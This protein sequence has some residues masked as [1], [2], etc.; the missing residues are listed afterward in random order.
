MKSQEIE[1]FQVEE[2]QFQNACANAIINCVHDGVITP[3][4]KRSLLKYILILYH[5]FELQQH[6]IKL[7][8]KWDI[9]VG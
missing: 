9:Q 6:K 7:V 5:L 1:Y 2:V 3:R 4:D 8:Q